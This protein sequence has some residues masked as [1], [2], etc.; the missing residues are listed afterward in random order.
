MKGGG[1]SLRKIYCTGAWKL[2][3]IPLSNPLKSPMGAHFHKNNLAGPL[4]GYGLVLNAFDAGKYII[5]ASG[6]GPWI[7]RLFGPQMALA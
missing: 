2:A 7:S 1:S 4:I 6:S 5:W 3:T